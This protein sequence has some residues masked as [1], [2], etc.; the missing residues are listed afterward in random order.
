[1]PLDKPVHVAFPVELVIDFES[2]YEPLD[3]YLLT[4]TDVQLPTGVYC[5]PIEIELLD[6]LDAFIAGGSGSVLIEEV[7]E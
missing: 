3:V 7:F 6:V 5:N 2:R 1:M 4:V